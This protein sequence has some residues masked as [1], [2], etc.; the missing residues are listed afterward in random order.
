MCAGPR[1]CAPNPPYVS[2][3][4]RT[5]NSLYSCG[6]PFLFCALA[7]LGTVIGIGL[8]SYFLFSNIRLSILTTLLAAVLPYLVFFDRMAL[9]DSL[10]AMFL[11]W[12]FNFSYLSFIHR[13]LDLAMFAGFALGFAWLTKSPAIFAFFLL[14]LNFLFIPKY[15]AKNILISSF[16]FLVSVAIAFGMYNI[17]RLG[18]EFHQIA[19]RNADYVFPLA[20]I[21]RHLLDP[22][23]P[24][25]KDSFLFF[26]YF[27]TPLGLLAAITGILAGGRSRWR[28]RLVLAAW[29]LGPV[30]VQ[31]AIARAFTARYLL[32]TVPFAAILIGHALEHIG[33]RTQKHF[34]SMAAAGLIILPALA[35]DYLA[36][37]RPES[38]PLPRIERSGYL[39]DWTAGYGLRDVAQ[40]L[41]QYAAAGPVLVGSE[42]FFGTPFNALQLYLNDVSNVRVIGV[43]VW[44]DSVHEKLK[45]SLADN[46]VFLVVNSTRLHADPDQIG[47]KL[48]VSYPKA[49]RPDGTREYLLFFQVLSK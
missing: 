7:G 26:A 12:T 27:L 30:L 8:A 9:A 21:L 6:S 45:N 19:L 38:L 25:L 40:R 43:G 31:S 2:C 29:W 14:P 22:L 18:P 34:L 48:I 17:L 24:H 13:R 39:E 20:E 36:V 1:S 44:I 41:R 11:V 37:A 46:Q 47:L 35:M 49:Y 33:Q 23:L 15:S 28:T 10:L 3:L 42:G 32:F 16:Y 4:S 5:A